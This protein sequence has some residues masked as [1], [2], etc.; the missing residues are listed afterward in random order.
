MR[1]HDHDPAGSRLPIELDTTSNGEFAPIPLAPVHERANRLAHEAADQAARQGVRPQR[2]E[3][4]R[5]FRRRPEPMNPFSDL[6][7]REAATT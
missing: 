7:P 5:T 1:E 4:L 3:A 6:A 2:P